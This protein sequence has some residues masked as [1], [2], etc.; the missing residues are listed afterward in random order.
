MTQANVQQIH[1]E[2]VPA[3][4]FP[5]FLGSRDHLNAQE[6]HSL[7]ELEP[8]THI[9]GAAGDVINRHR[10]KLFPL[11]RCHHGL[12]AGRSVL[13]PVSPSSVY[14]AFLLPTLRPIRTQGFSFAQNPKRLGFSMSKTT[15]YQNVSAYILF[16]GVQRLSEQPQ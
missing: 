7:S 3:G 10:L 16:S 12:E 2:V 14:Y 13:V 6:Q 15:Q 9:T 8:I 4:W 5:Q 11:R 1:K